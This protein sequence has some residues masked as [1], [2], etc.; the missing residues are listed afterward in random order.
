M[1]TTTATTAS[2][3]TASFTKLNGEWAVKTDRKITKAD[4][5]AESRMVIGGAKEETQVCRL[6]VILKSGAAKI[7]E[8]LE[9]AAKNENGHFYFVR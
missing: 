8:V 5:V 9:Y 1:N 7:V 3:I 4:Y 2:P 6:E